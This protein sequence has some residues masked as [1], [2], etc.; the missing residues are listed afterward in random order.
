MA[1][2]GKLIVIG[3]SIDKGSFSVNPEKLPNN[4]K[5]FEKGILKRMIDESDKGLASRIGRNRVSPFAA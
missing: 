1:P 3:G 5:F 4:L 2:K